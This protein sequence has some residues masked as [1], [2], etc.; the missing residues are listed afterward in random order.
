MGDLGDRGLE[1]LLVA[2]ARLAKAAE[3]ADV[4]AGGGLQFARRRR[5]A[6][7]TQGLDASAHTATVKRMRRDRQPTTGR[8]RIVRLAWAVLA[9]LALAVAVD[10]VRTG[11]PGTWLA[12]RGLPAPYVPLGERVDI[13]GRSIYLDCRG[14]GSPTVV[15]D[16]G[17]GSGAGSWSSVFGD[18]A[19]TTRTCAYDRPGRG[20]SDPRGRHTLADTTADLRAAL[21]VKGER[22]PFVLVG[23][24]HGGNYLRIFGDR[25]REETAGLVF[26]DSFD[27]DLET[28]FIHPLLGP[29]R[30]E[31]E[32]ALD[33]L[34]ALVAQVEELDW[35]ASEREMRD[36]SLSG[37]PIEILRAPRFEP[38][39]DAATNDAIAAAIIASYESLS[40]G[41]VRFELAWGAGHMIQ[42]DRPDLVVA[43]TRRLVDAARAASR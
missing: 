36:A 13:G 4:L 6:R 11:G 28:D 5:F 27:P 41:M 39:V 26:V 15:L 37:I 40:P 24:S 20:S 3:L 8:A 12:L 34:R 1:R 29:V 22:A 25:Y 9:G 42:V 32:A 35:V 31:Y 23:H 21:G 10:V 30:P 18:L 17:M 7:A 38:R 33:N 16:A 19:S 14:Q 43:A 2:S